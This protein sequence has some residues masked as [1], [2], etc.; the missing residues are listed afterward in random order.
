MTPDSM[1]RAPNHANF[2]HYAFHRP[3][4]GRSV[5]YDLEDFQ[6]NQRQSRQRNEGHEPISSTNRQ[7]YRRKNEG[8]KTIISDNIYDVND[9][10]SVNEHPIIPPFRMM[11]FPRPRESSVVNDGDPLTTC[12]VATN[13][14]TIP[15]D[16]Q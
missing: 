16:F 8:Y 14:L 3:V 6:H 11:A 9:D 2:V 7:Q 12:A 5:F 15:I 13:P 10:G 1:F 4:T